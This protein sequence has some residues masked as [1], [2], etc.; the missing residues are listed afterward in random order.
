[1]PA[2]IHDPATHNEWLEALGL[3]GLP[4]DIQMP[5]LPPPVTGLKQ[6]RQH[7]LHAPELSAMARLGQF[8]AGQTP[9]EMIASTMSPQASAGTADHYTNLMNNNGNLKIPALSPAERAVRELQ[10]FE[11]AIPMTAE[12][13]AKGLPQLYPFGGQAHLSNGPIFGAALDKP[14]AEAGSGS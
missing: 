5:G 6:A 3:D 10:P 13:Q 4:P 1:M 7:P 2:P 9:M 12:A 14:Y 8:S 11:R